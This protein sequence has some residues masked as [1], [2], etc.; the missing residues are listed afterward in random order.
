MSN[1]YIIPPTNL[2]IP[3]CYYLGVAD[4][5]PTFSRVF[6]VLP[7][8][9]SPEENAMLSRKMFESI[10]QIDPVWGVVVE[11]GTPSLSCIT[12]GEFFRRFAREDGSGIV[13]ILAPVTP[14]HVRMAETMASLADS[15][16]RYRSRPRVKVIVDEDFGF[17]DFSLPMEQYAPVGPSESET[18]SKKFLEEG[19][20]NIHKT[21]KALKKCVVVTYSNVLDDYFEK[22]AGTKGFEDVSMKV[23]LE[24]MTVP[25][26][27]V[28]HALKSVP[29][30]SYHKSISLLA[31]WDQYL[32]D[33]DNECVKESYE[34]ESKGEDA[35]KYGGE[36]KVSL[37]REGDRFVF[38]PRV[39]ISGL[40][41]H[42][43]WSL[44][45][46][47]IEA[48]ENDA[49]AKHITFVLLGD[50][51]KNGISD[52]VPHIKSGRL[53]HV[54]PVPFHEYY[55]TLLR[56]APT[57]GLILLDVTHPFNWTKSPL[58][59]VEYVSLGIPTLYPKSIGGCGPLTKGVP[60]TKDT[61]VV[62]VDDRLDGYEVYVTKKFRGFESPWAG[63][64]RPVSLRI[65]DKPHMFCS[66][67]GSTLFQGM[68]F[69]DVLTDPDGIVKR[70]VDHL[71]KAIRES[72]GVSFMKV[73]MTQAALC[74]V[75]S[76]VV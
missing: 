32:A 19:W 40:A 33:K 30:I 24:D 56:L 58:K 25:K 55:R 72:F 26:A 37:I 67:G 34:F 27:A 76:F 62:D 66:I 6:I 7:E 70:Y 35:K 50:L 63:R 18:L 53:E 47:I 65:S 61:V 28:A 64:T 31:L 17:F 75:Y 46:R 48:S 12:E 59:L 8:S 45:P 5:N 39:L 49:W 74:P 20:T 38:P 29:V 21:L 69:K 51:P 42:K 14:W 1:V 4:E 15:I 36:F 22:V 44:L 23:V 52:F 10:V 68:D 54:R 16:H 60:E 73:R 9:R 11:G 3:H 41:H 2:S 13:K 57:F 71:S 43:D